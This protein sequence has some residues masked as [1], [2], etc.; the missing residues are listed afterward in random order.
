MQHIEPLV[1][2]V[3]RLNLKKMNKRLQEAFIKAESHAQYQKIGL[4]GEKSPTPPWLWRK[5]KIIRKIVIR[6]TF[7]MLI[8]HIKLTN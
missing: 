3:E 6:E 8:H 7:D 4:W 2:N 1:V 5:K